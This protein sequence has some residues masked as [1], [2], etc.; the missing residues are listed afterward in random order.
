MAMS[1]GVTIT[2]IAGADHR[3]IGAEVRQRNSHTPSQQGNIT[4][5]GQGIEKGRY[6]RSIRFDKMAKPPQLKQFRAIVGDYLTLKARYIGS[7]K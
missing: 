4:E 2:R 6:G 5:I 1:T 7:Q 3:S